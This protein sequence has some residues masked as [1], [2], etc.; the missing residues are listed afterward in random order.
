VQIID[1]LRAALRRRHYALATEE[2]YLEWARRFIRFHRGRHPSELG[3]DELTAFLEHLVVRLNLAASTQNQALCAIIFMY[4]YVLDRDLGHLEPFAFARKPRRL[5]VVLT[6]TEVAAALECVSAPF[7]LFAR[8]LYGTGLRLGEGVRLRV[9]DLDFGQGQLVVRRGKGQVDR[10]TLLPRSLLEP[11][12]AQIDFVAE[13]LVRDTGSGVGPVELPFALDRKLPR[14]GRE[15]A[16][17]WVFPSE[18]VEFDHIGAP[19]RPHAP[20]RLIQ[21][22]V[23]EAVVSAGVQKAASAHTHRHSFATHLLED[24]TDIRV[25]QNLLGHRSI[26]TTMIYTHVVQR[27][28]LGVVSPLD[29]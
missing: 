1:Q 20:K 19:R 6:P 26:K 23:H 5:P 18:S 7:Q 29:F 4:R 17:Q 11:L 22:S 3:A 16:W 12:R 24:G 15:L 25:I 14:A 28:P 27:G 2:A 21:S 9:Q 13:Q 8:L 10:V